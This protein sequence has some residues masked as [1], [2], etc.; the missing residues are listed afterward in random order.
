MT[1]A[2]AINRLTK[3][4]GRA[5]AVRQL[6]LDVPFETIFALIGSNGAGKSTTLRCIVGLSTPTSGRILINNE[7]LTPK[8]FERL[9]YVPDVPACYGW[10]TVRD[11]LDMTRGQF[12]A[13]DHG[14]AAA[15]L[16]RFQL[17]PTKK[18]RALSKGQ[19]TALSLVLAFCVRPSIIVLDEPMSGL[20]PGSQRHALDLMVAAAADGAAVLVSSHHVGQMERVAEN[21]AILHSGLIVESGRVEDLLASH[22]IVEAIR[23]GEAEEAI[24]RVYT[25]GEDVHALRSQLEADGASIRILDVTLEDIYLHAVASDLSG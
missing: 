3:T 20:D 25:N 4:Y 2:I 5:V 24:R 8:T 13:Y 17:S 22:K 7:T 23:G 1:A 15:L 21:V 9:A 14:R 18:V 10:L 19:Q 6:S 16:D 11:H 12:K